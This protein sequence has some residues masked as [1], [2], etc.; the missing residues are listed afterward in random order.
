VALAVSTYAAKYV[1]PELPDGAAKRAEM[2]GFVSSHAIWQVTP[3]RA[4]AI[5]E[6]EEDFAA[7]AT[8]WVW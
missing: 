3:T 8:R 7:K 2:E 5:I 1:D 6:R 4:Y